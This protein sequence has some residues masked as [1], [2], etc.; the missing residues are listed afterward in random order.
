MTLPSVPNLS[1]LAI[2]TGPVVAGRAEE[3]KEELKNI[4][5]NL[6]RSN[7]DVGELA[8]E[9]KKNGYYQDRYATFQEYAKA[10][11]PIKLRKLQYLRR[12]VEVCEAVGIERSIYEPLG[13]AK[14]RDITSLD[15]T[16]DWVNPQTQVVT[17]MKE[18]I[19]EFINNG[20]NLTH[21][22]IKTHVRTLKGL[23]GEK[24]ILWH[25]W[26][27]T[28]E[29]DENVIKPGLELARRNIGSVGKD[30]EGNAVDASDSRAIEV[31]FAEYL[32]DPNNQV[33]GEE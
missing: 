3:A 21:E 11:L 19:V 12:I 10:E 2:I 31:I 22:E 15:Y 27:F 5:N 17:P 29:V 25:N 16:S 30:D 23:V 32:A 24:D 13:T 26:P 28:R 18:F 8:H 4:V 1:T 20:L 14:L 6:N 33:T 9:V 7:F